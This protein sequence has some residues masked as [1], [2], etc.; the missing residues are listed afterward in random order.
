MSLP[1]DANGK[2][3]QFEYDGKGQLKAVVDAGQKRT[4]YDYDNAG[5]LSIVKDANNQVTTYEYDDKGRRQTIIIHATKPSTIAYN[6]AEKTVTITDFNNKRVK[7]TY[8]DL[9]QLV[10][11]QY[12]N[13]SGATVSVSYTVDGLE[14][15]ITD[16][17]ARLFTSTTIWGSYFLAKTL[18]VL[19]LPAV[20]RSN[21][22]TKAGKLLRLRLRLA[23]RTIPTI[24][25][26]I[27]RVG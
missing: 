27:L 22:S 10:S 19:I 23:L 16:S 6:D 12:Q 2:T 24:L 17:R 21:T 9:N 14:K 26:E 8:N 18:Q 13:K 4:E 20:I 7:Y 5:N 15:T 25:K 1:C 3:T 11:K